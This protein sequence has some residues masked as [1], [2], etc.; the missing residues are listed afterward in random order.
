LGAQREHVLRKVLFD[1]IRPAL[2][3][4]I[5]GLATSA[6]SVRLIR[7]ILYQTQPL[8]PA[9]FVSVAGLLLLVAIAA[10][11]TPAWHAARLDP[12]DA[13]RSE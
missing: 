3:G 10:C 8:D 4:L 12:I 5:A 11:L 7:S 6:A 9:V 1:G 2:V 13:L